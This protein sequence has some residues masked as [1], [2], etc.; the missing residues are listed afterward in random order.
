[1][2]KK[3]EKTGLAFIDRVREVAKEL[4]LLQEKTPP[5]NPAALI[6]LA[7]QC[8]GGKTMRNCIMF[9]GRNDRFYTF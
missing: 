2:E 8:T 5:E 1:M 3:D 4:Q 6:V 7:T 9:A